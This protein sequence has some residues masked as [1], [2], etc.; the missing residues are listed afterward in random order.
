MITT[1]AFNY[2]DTFHNEVANEAIAK[3]RT[4]IMAADA[5]AEFHSKVIN[6]IEDIIAEAKREIANG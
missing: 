3:I 6:S 4:I 1:P 5:T 2:H